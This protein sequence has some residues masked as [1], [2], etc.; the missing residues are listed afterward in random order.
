[1]LLIFFLVTSSM[2][3][4]KGVPRQLPPPE[5]ENTEQEYFVKDRNVLVLEIDAHD[6]LTCNQ[7][8]ITPA[9]LTQRIVEFVANADNDPQLP[10]LSTREVH[11]MGKCRVSDRHIISVQVDRHTSYRAY[12]DM[13]N[14][15]VAG[16][17]K[18]RNRLA[19]Q[20][21]RHSLAECTPEESDAIALVYPQRISEQPI[22]TSEKGGEP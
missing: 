15:I 5:D 7:E 22:R 12:M 4:E 21:F 9:Q 3:N 2:K 8:D 16:Y 20:R 10:E 6:R 1:M 19:Q 11:L 14:A 17:H 18:V 13:Q